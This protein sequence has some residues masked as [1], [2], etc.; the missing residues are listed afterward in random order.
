MWNENEHPREKDGKFTDKESAYNS[1][2]NFGN[3]KKKYIGPKI[4]YRIKKDIVEVELNS[5]IQKEFDTATAKERQKI[6]F[7]YIMDNLRGKYPI[8][9]GEEVAI[10]RVGADKMSHT[11]NEIKIRVLPEL[12]N[13]IKISKFKGVVDVNHNIFKKFAYY[14]TF[15]SIKNETYSAR[16]NIGIRKN[17]FSTLYDINP[18]SKQK[19]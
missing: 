6:A 11:L 7:K 9:N 1:Q 13:L 5:E 8:G 19:K 14:D 3:L 12:A 10:E 2:D 18:F 4:T 15:F 17:G 16:L